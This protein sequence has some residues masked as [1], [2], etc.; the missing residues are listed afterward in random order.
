MYKLRNVAR[1][2]LYT[3][4]GM[5]SK[6]TTRVAVQ[7]GKFP[8]SEVGGERTDHTMGQWVCIGR[9]TPAVPLGS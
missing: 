5:L 2:C 9:T 1:A 6:H 8:Y 7:R 4:P 3:R